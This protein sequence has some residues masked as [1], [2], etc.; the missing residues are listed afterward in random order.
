MDAKT[1]EYVCPRCVIPPIRQASPGKN[2]SAVSPSLIAEANPSASVRKSIVQLRSRSTVTHSKPSSEQTAAN[3]ASLPYPERIT[4][5]ESQ[6][7]QLAGRSL[8]GS[9]ATKTPDASKRVIWSAPKP[10]MSA[11][12]TRFGP[13][14]PSNILSKSSAVDSTIDPPL[15]QVLFS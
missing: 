2:V 12:V 5:C 4:G 14:H 11:S 13:G 15:S 1:I 9:A 7:P 6:H 10:Q 8:I 3:R